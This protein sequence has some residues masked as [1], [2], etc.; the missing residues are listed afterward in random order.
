MLSVLAFY[1]KAF[2]YYFSTTVKF[3]LV[4]FKERYFFSAKCPTR[5]RVGKYAR[6]CY[7]EQFLP[8]VNCYVLI[9]GQNQSEAVL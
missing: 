9:A 3:Q 8:E 7:L 5:P 2:F 1:L 6:L 4:F